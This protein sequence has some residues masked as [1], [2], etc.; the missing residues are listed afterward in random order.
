MHAFFMIDRSL[1]LKGTYDDIENVLITVG[2]K[3]SKNGFVKIPTGKFIMG[4]EG[5]EADESPAHEVEI[6]SF[7]L[8]VTPVTE[9]QWYKLMGTAQEAERYKNSNKPKTNVSFYGSVLYCNR[10]SI[11]EKKKP[12]YD[13]KTFMRIPGANGYYLPSESQM[14][15]A[16]RAETTSVYY[17]PTITKEAYNLTGEL[18]DVGQFAPNPWGIFDLIGSIRQWTDDFY[19]K[20]RI[21]TNFTPPSTGSS[22]MCYGASFKDSKELYRVTYRFF[23]EPDFSDEF[24]GFRIAYS[25]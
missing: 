12:A 20:Y 1:S 8:G 10:K 19:D 2:D 15:Y 16:A 14:Q 5:F 7:F 11:V 3:I 22:K 24:L 13:E 17:T 23:H 9:A 25:E 21:E 4:A 18:T 6:D